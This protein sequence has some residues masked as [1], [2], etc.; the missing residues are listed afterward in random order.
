MSLRVLRP[1]GEQLQNL[2]RNRSGDDGG[3]QTAAVLGVAT[4]R[5]VAIG[6]AHRAAVH[7]IDGA[8]IDAGSD[9]LRANDA[10]QV[11]VRLAEGSI[12]DGHAET[13]S[14]GQALGDVI[15]HFEAALFDVRSDGRDDVCRR[16]KR[17]QGLDSRTDG[18]R[19]GSDPAAV[20]RRDGSRRSIAE[21]DADAIGGANTACHAWNIRGGDIAFAQQ[22]FVSIFR[23]GEH[24]GV[25]AVDLT[26]HE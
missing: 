7:V 25:R 14:V 9:E 4:K 24:D 2:L 8:V 22:H 15:V 1:P 23:T 18:I 16:R 3:E 19:N 20:N 11:H 13:R 6:F 26:E 17:T 21:Q 12:D 10:S 5:E